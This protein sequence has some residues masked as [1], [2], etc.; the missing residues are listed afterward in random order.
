VDNAGATSLKRGAGSEGLSH[1]VT[2]LNVSIQSLSI[3]VSSVQKKVVL[4]NSLKRSQRKKRS[5]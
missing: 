5:S 2:T 1:A 4:E 3:S